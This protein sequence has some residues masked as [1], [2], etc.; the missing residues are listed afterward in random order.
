MVT[1]SRAYLYS[2]CQHSIDY[3]VCV[4]VG[5]VFIANNR[6]AAKTCLKIK[7]FYWHM[8]LQLS[9]VGKISEVV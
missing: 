6:K 4:L 1:S 2:A 9:E 8:Y 7:M 5:I 3:K